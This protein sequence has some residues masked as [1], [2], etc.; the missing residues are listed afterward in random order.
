VFTVRHGL[1]L[2]KEL[3]IEYMKQLSID[4]I[5]EYG[6]TRQQHSDR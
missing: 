4:H 2:K 1:R 5:K 3:S 6:T